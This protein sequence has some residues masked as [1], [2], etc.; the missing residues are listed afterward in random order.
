MDQEIH[1]I[2]RIAIRNDFNVDVPWLVRK[3]R[4]RFL[5]SQSSQNPHNDFICERWIRLPFLGKHSYKLARE[6]RKLDF[7]VGF[8]PL[9]TIGQLLNHKESIPTNKKS[10]VYR[11]NCG[12]CDAQYVGPTGRSLMNRIGDHRHAFNKR[13]VSEGLEENHDF[14]KV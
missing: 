7:R 14:T 6:L 12:E 10:G 9:I 1:T 11:L 2:Q 5:L 8:Y 4:L 13:N 3:K